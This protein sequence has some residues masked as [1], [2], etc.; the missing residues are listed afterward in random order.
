MKE[1]WESLQ[2][3]PK[4]CV[5]SKQE[6]ETVGDL[7]VHS[8]FDRLLLR[9]WAFDDNT[10][11]TSLG[12]GD[13]ESEGP[14]VLTKYGTSTVLSGRMGNENKLGTRYVFTSPRERKESCVSIT[15]PDSTPRFGRTVEV[16]T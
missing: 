9:R 16:E 3:G 6:G 4:V 2:N 8:R 15:V 13:R 5:Q 10:G 1:P 12:G 11:G 7:I 14:L